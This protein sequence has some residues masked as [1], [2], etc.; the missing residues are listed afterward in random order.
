VQ[1]KVEHILNGSTPN[2]ILHK[3]FV[4]ICARNRF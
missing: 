2:T 1:S 3:T 4:I